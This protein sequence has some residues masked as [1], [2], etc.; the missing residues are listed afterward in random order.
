MFNDMQCVYLKPGDLCFADTN[1]VIH[2]VLGSCVSITMYCRRLKIGIMTHCM[3][4]NSQES[5]H[6]GENCMKYVDCA[7]IYLNKKFTEL[8]ISKQET[9]VKL[10]GGSDMFMAGEN[11]ATVGQRNVNASRSMLEH[12]GYII[13]ASD[14]GGGFTRKIYFSIET[15]TVY[16]RKISR[17]QGL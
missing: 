17:M 10:F 9:E 15:G 2:T 14:T 3:L 16:Q 1:L 7:V 11:A 5:V 4:P 6:Q 8:N 13:A 12:M